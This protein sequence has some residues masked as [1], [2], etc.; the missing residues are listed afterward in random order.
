MTQN[1]A[2][3]RG[4]LARIGLPAPVELPLSNAM[5]T[6]FLDTLE[7]GALALQL[8]RTG[9]LRQPEGHGVDKPVQ[10]APFGA[11]P[12]AATAVDPACRDALMAG[13]AEAL[14]TF[15]PTQPRPAIRAA[16]VE[17]P[18]APTPVHRYG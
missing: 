12:L 16:S 8:S 1:A 14:E 13:L 2:Y 5:L 11:N 10:A 9:P 6:E 18:R 4:T 7:E 3:H 17:L 15:K